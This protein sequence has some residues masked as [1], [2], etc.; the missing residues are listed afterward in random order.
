[1]IAWI[2]KYEN[3]LRTSKLAKLLSSI[4]NK[5]HKRVTRLAP[6]KINRLSKKP[7]RQKKKAKIKKL[8]AA[9]ARVKTKQLLSLLKKPPKLLLLKRKLK[10]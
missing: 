5:F 1:M 2:H 6:Q 4:M 7:P 3:W 10:S 8:S 9:K